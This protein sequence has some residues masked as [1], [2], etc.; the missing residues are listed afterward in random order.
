MLS[1]L[2]IPRRWVLL[3]TLGPLIQAIKKLSSE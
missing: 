3:T 2:S 1:R